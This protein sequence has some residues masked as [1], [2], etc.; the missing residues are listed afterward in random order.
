[1]KRPRICSGASSLQ[2]PWWRRG[3]ALPRP[4]YSCWGF[5]PKPRRRASPEPR[6]CPTRLRPSSSGRTRTF[7]CRWSTGWCAGPAPA[8]RTVPLHFALSSDR[9]KCRGGIFGYRPIPQRFCRLKTRSKVGRRPPALR[10]YGCG[11]PL[12]RS[13]QCARMHLNVWTHGVQNSSA[14]QSSCVYDAAYP[15]SG[16]TL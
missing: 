3:T 14:V 9:V 1:M 4:G 2:F 12:F 11:P 13:I 7:S 6:R 10:G 15:L 5:E 8:T 16:A